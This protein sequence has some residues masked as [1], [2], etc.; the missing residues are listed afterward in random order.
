MV[1]IVKFYYEL[2][3]LYSSFIMVYLVCYKSSQNKNT[4]EDGFISY[5]QISADYG[6]RDF[7][8]PK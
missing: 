2:F 5:M 6:Q 4:P 3:A 7:N 1:T 8:F